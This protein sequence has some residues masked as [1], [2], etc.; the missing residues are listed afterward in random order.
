[1]T[2]DFNRLDTMIANDL[3]IRGKWTDGQERACL[4]AALAPEC[5]AA[6]SA[7]ACPAEKMWPWLAY[8]TPWIDDAGSAEAW[9]GVVRRYAAAVRRLDFSRDGRPV[10][11]AC[12]RVILVEARGHDRSGS[13]DAVIALI[14][15]GAAVDD[16]RWKSARAASW[17]WAAA[18]AAGAEA[19]AAAEAAAEAAADAAAAD[20]AAADAAAEAAADAAAAAAEAEA[21]A[22]AAAAADRLIDGILTALESAGAQ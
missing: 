2:L 18:W 3:L 8:L 11:L 9:P 1:M 20:A 12:L 5:G 4:L 17:A 6:N 16:P 21:A 19:D 15:E 7:A 14:D 10:L 13:C 22:D